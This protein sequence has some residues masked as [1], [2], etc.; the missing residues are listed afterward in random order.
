M[1]STRTILYRL[2]P[3][4]FVLCSLYRLLAFIAKRVFKIVLCLLG[5]TVKNAA[6]GSEYVNYKNK[7]IKRD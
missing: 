4:H 1:Q 7:I 6:S 5:I 2:F 3:T